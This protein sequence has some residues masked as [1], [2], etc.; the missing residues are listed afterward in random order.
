MVFPLLVVSNWHDHLRSTPAPPTAQQHLLDDRIPLWWA[1]AS[2]D[3]G[4]ERN[5]PQAEPTYSRSHLIPP[6]SH[7]ERHSFSERSPI[8]SHAP[9][10]STLS[11]TSSLSH[12]HSHSYSKSQSSR[13]GGSAISQPSPL[14]PTSTSSL[15]LYGTSPPIAPVTSVSSRS[16]EAAPSSQA[17]LVAH[18]ASSSS[19][20][21]AH[22]YSQPQLA[23]LRQ[24]ANTLASTS[25]TSH[26]VRSPSPGFP[27]HLTL[28]TSGGSLLP[29]S[30]Q[31][32]RRPLPSISGEV[33]QRGSISGDRL[34][35]KLPPL[36]PMDPSPRHE[37]VFKF[38]SFWN[39][40]TGNNGGSG[41]GTPTGLTLG[42]P[43]GDAN[44]AGVGKTKFSSPSPRFN[45]YS[46]SGKRSSIGGPGGIG[47][48][49]QEDKVDSRPVS[50]KSIP[51]TL[52]PERREEETNGKPATER[53][54]ER[55]VGGPV[56]IQALIS[57]AE[58]KSK[59]R[60]TI[61]GL[62]VAA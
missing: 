14:P 44:G 42:G 27:G 4:F 34:E 35:I 24:R 61:R 8:S 16:A 46:S 3:W 23:P 49:G 45:P 20:G 29:S 13:P 19:S 32:G 52:V 15:G 1:E 28:S 54:E 18:S 39:N 55:D 56:G 31:G 30:V 50:P 6:S 25:V 12:R 48:F 36:P 11:T 43:L 37:G 58:E 47:R 5:P 40:A 51:R 38:P 60:E 53:G 10:S 22:R 57:A 62:E 9:P 33:P 21:A 26:R 2:R 59:E 7:P 17:T 41:S